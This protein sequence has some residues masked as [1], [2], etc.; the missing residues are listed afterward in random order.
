LRQ[1]PII[2]GAR[3]EGEAGYADPAAP[4]FKVPDFTATME[5]P[6]LFQSTTGVEGRQLVTVKR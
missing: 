4:P 6:F 1:N 3:L 5:P 2:S